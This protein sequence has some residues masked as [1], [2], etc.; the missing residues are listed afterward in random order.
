MHREYFETRFWVSVDDI[1][2]FEVFEESD[3]V[4]LS[5]FATTGQTWTLEQNTAADLALAARVSGVS[6]RVR[7]I[8]YSPRTMHAE[9]S[10]VVPLGLET[11]RGLGVEFAQDAIY[12]IRGGDLYVVRSLGGVAYWVDAWRERLDWLDAETMCERLEGYLPRGFQL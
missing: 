6:P 2:H 10:W 12:W 5:A 8:G 1:R 9:P 3:W 11:G 7:V 4:V